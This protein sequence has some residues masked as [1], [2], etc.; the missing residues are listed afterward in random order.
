MYS[1]QDGLHPNAKLRGFKSAL[2]LRVLMCKLHHL[3]TTC[4]LQM[5]HGPSAFAVCWTDIMVSCQMKWWQTPTQSGNTEQLRCSDSRSWGQLFSFTL[6]GFRVC[7]KKKKALE[8]RERQ[9]QKDKMLPAPLFSIESAVSSENVLRS[10]C[11]RLI[12]S[13]LSHFYIWMA[14]E[15]KGHLGFIFITGNSS[16]RGLMAADVARLRHNLKA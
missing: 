14:L 13:W 15:T 2:Q 10:Q 4:R 6:R 3:S 5:Q 11:N 12:P 9:A 7:K 1:E 8:E 16:P